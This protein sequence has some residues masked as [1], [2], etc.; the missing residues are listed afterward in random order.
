MLKIALPEA[1][2]MTFVEKEL[3]KEALG[4][5][6]KK[7]N[8]IYA[9]DKNNEANHEP[10]LLYADGAD[11]L[12]QNKG[13]IALYQTIKEMGTDPFLSKFIHWMASDNSYKT[14]E[15]FMGLLKPQLKKQTYQIYLDG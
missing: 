3:G 9:K 6:I 15:S 11:Y 10:S 12:E 7:K 5:L 2:A 4:H 8:D 14:F 1:L 13:A